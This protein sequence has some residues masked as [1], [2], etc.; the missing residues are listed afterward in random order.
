M[1]ALADVGRAGATRAGYTSGRV[2][3][4]IAGADRT[5]DTRPEGFSLTPAIY[6]PP[7]TGTIRVAGTRPTKG[8]PI[9][10]TVGSQNNYQRLFGGH[11]LAADQVYEGASE[12]LPKWDCA[13]IDAS[14]RLDFRKINARYTATAVEA[15]VVD[16]VAKAAPPGI[17]TNHVQAI[18][19]VINEFTCTNEDLSD[20]L[21]R[22]KVL[23][24]AERYVD[25]D[26]DLHFFTT[27]SLQNPTP[28]TLGQGFEDFSF[29]EDLSPVRTRVLYEGGGAP[30][31]APVA[32]GETILPVE[33]ASW[34][35]AGGGK[36][37]LGPQRVTYTG[38][39]LGGGGALVGPGVTPGAAP[40]I[41][42]AGGSGIESGVHQW[43]YTWVTAAGETRPSPLT[44]VTI[45]GTVSDPTGTIAPMW[46]YSWTGSMIWAIGD[47][48]YF[49]VTYLIAGGGETLAGATSATVVVPSVSG[50][51]SLNLLQ[52]IPV[53]SDGAVT[54]KRLYVNVNG[55]WVGYYTLA[56]ATT[57]KSEVGAD[58]GVTAGSPPGSNTAAANQATVAGIAVGPTG[59]TSRKVY[60]TVAGGSQLKLQQT[61]ANNTATTGVTDATADAALG[62]NAPTGDTSGLTQP[63]GQVNPGSTTLLLA[64][65]A[66]FPAAG[67]AILPGGQ[68]VRYTSISGNTL[69]GIPA[70]GDGAIL[71]AVSY[72]ATVTAAPI[73]TG[74]PASGTGAVLYAVAKGE[75]ANLVVQVDDV[76]AQLALVALVDPTAALGFDGVVEDYQQ[77]NRLS[78]VEATLR[79]Q[80][81]LGLVKDAHGTIRYT[82]RDR[83]T[84][85]GATITVS[86]AAAPVAVS[87]DFLIQQVTIAAVGQLLYYQVEASTRRYS[88]EALLRRLRAAA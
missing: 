81:R 72:N 68:I 49:A 1:Y 69:S 26:G 43:A 25:Y 22:L 28:L 45:G 57:A 13:L 71:A 44:Q 16:L 66:N 19:T 70:S 83:I 63:T 8:N 39:Q 27:E 36:V 64:S 62:A 76:A 12:D 56:P 59:T 42:R 50:H 33:D 65:P 54:S 88:L 74:V 34:Y 60:R 87:G 53:S 4:A 41:A 51:P 75:Q 77:D 47:S 2:F 20:A 9:V 31:L 78:I 23:V 38:R 6:G 21:D 3:T 15:I 37:A 14:W 82:T 86:M 67:W 24:G 30:L 11:I 46:T 40:V 17:T 7:D 52:N 18:G 80:A 85:V 10:L 84:R 79:A 73:V 61:I 35:D 29:S 55:A 32:A 58:T 48:V 5:N